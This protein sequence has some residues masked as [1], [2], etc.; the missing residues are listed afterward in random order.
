MIDGLVRARLATAG[1]ETMT[2]GAKPVEV[3][4]LQITAAGRNAIE[5]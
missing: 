2:V 1:R 3:V 4:R 5:E